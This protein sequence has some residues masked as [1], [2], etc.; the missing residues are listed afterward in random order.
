MQR[1]TRL[2]LWNG[3]VPIMTNTLEMVKLSIWV[4]PDERLQRVLFNLRRKDWELKLHVFIWSIWW[5]NANVTFPQK[6]LLIFSLPGGKFQPTK[7]G[8][9]T[10]THHFTVDLPLLSFNPLKSHQKL[11]VWR[12]AAS[13]ESWP[14]LN[15]QPIPPDWWH[16]MPASTGLP[17]A[18]HWDISWERHQ[19]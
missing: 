8:K 12:S 15:R 7:W 11:N 4:G 19:C 18:G 1:C 9:H 2:V 13:K 17:A 10:I 14:P 5:H 16:K 3:P 6:F